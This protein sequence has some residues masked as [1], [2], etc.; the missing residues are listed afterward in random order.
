[1]LIN[2]LKTVNNYCEI[3]IAQHPIEKNYYSTEKQNYS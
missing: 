3:K 1:M 2:I